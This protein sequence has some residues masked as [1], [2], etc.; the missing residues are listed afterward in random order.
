ERVLA[1]PAVGRTSFPLTGNEDVERKRST[2]LNHDLGRFHDNLHGVTL[3]QTEFF[4]TGTRDHAFDQVLTDL[5]YDMRHDLADLDRLDRTGELIS[6]REG[7]ATFVSLFARNPG[8]RE[9]R[10]AKYRLIG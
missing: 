2:L 6:R 10:I 3:F 9:S 5:D 7:H 1:V 4:G 8:I